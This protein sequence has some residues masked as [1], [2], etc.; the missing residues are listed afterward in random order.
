MHL[1][2]N[3]LAKSRPECMANKQLRTTRDSFTPICASS[4]SSRPY[5]LHLHCLHSSSST[6]QGPALSQF[7]PCPLPDAP[8]LMVLAAPTGL[9]LVPLLALMLGLVVLALVL[10]RV[11]AP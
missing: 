11:A 7:A 8:P 4:S 1:G 2:L 5:D 3:G 9:V 6:L 10:V